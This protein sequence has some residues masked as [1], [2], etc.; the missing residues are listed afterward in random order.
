MP[1]GDQGQ[2]P[3][4]LRV[5]FVSPLRVNFPPTVFRVNFATRPAPTPRHPNRPTR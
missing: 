2:G 4:Q 1:T 5:R 3:V